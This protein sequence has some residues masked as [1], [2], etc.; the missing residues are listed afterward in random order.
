MKNNYMLLISLI[1]LTLTFG[2]D[3]ASQPVATT[4]SNTAAGTVTF[5]FKTGDDVRRVEIQDVAD[6]ATLESVLRSAAGVDVV[7]SG[8]G[9][10]AFVHQIGDKSTSSSEGWT[11][12][13]D[14]QWSE[15][16]VGTTQLHPP[17]TVTWE[18]GEMKTP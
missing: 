17:T 6:G 8:S 18:F 3:R 2:C 13:I 12:A 9:L 7:I 11:F 5:E 14:G 15:T 10:S 16:G 1:A 4:S